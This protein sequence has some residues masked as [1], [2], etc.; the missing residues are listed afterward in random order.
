MNDLESKLQVYFAL[1]EWYDP[2]CDILPTLKHG[3][4][5]GLNSY[6]L[7]VPNVVPNS[8]TTASFARGLTSCPKALSSGQ[9]ALTKML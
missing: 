5:N 2:Q 3:A 1:F 4:S 7:V 8:S 9:S 6:E